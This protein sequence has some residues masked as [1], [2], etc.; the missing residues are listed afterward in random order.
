MKKHEVIKRTN[1]WF[2]VNMHILTDVCK[3]Q[4][5]TIIKFIFSPNNYR[6]HCDQ[7]KWIRDT[8][9]PA[10]CEFR[11]FYEQNTAQGWARLK[12]MKSTDVL[13]LDKKTLFL[14]RVWNERP[15]YAAKRRDRRPKKAKTT[16]GDQ[17][18]DVD[19]NQPGEVRHGRSAR[20]CGFSPIV[21]YP[22][23][24]DEETFREA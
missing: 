20:R 23:D 5:K 14:K 1:D 16:N 12:L 7:W 4:S 9:A 24:R 15:R 8:L 17:R 19:N 2:E 6:E 22:M 3:Y 13:L 21:R 11:A 10:M 18:L